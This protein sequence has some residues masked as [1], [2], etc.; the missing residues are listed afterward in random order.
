MTATA[1]GSDFE[2]VDLK[3]KKPKAT[4]HSS[5]KLGFNADAAS[6]MN[7]KKA[8]SFIVARQ[9]GNTAPRLFKLVEARDEDDHQVC[10]VAKA[11]NYYYLNIRAVFDEVG[12]DYRNQKIAFDIS[13]EDDIGGRKCFLLERLSEMN[14]R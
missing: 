5:G 14:S 11:G 4:I 2:V 12:F 1:I 3:P 7:F 13:R 6:L 9:K 8:P 10:R